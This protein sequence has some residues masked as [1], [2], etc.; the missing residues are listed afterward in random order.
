VFDSVDELEWHGPT[1]TLPAW[2]ERLKIVDRD[3]S[4]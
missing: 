1:A 2:R 3:A 4:D